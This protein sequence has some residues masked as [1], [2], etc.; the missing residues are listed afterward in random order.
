MIE[1]KST[2]TIGVLGNMIMEEAHKRCDK[3]EC[4]YCTY[5]D[6]EVCGLELEKEII[7]EVIE[8]LNRRE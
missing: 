5:E 7:E 8:Y 4:E 1:K 6:S 2:F 3:R